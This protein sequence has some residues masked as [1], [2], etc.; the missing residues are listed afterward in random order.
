VIVYHIAVDVI[1]DYVAK[2]EPHRHAHLE[3]LQGLRAAGILIGGGPAPDGSRADLFYRLQKPE[4]LKPAMEE[5]PYWTGG[6][7]TRYVPRSYAQFVEPWEM[8]PVVLDGSRRVTIVEGPTGDIDMA[9]LALVELRGAGR[10]AFGG[11]FEG[12]DTLAV[13]RSADP[14]EAAAWFTETGFWPEDRLRTRPFLHV[15]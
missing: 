6:V 11:C 2:R 3:R 10:I 13:A 1:D 5:D 12:G 4:Q 14:A 7:W 9:Q 15:L 8:V